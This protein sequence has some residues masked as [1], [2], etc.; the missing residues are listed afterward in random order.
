MDASLILVI[1]MGVVGCCVATAAPIA[2]GIRMGER[3][4]RRR[5]AA[6]A[7]HDP[8]EFQLWLADQRLDYI[9]E[10]RRKLE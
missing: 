7:H 1:G 2:A 6:Q 5:I 9:Q 8:T 4:E 3:R 10:L